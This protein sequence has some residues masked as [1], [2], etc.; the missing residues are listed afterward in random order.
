MTHAVMKQIAA[1]GLL[2]ALAVSPA[3]PAFAADSLGE[4]IASGDA[5]LDLRYRFEYVEQD[6]FSEKANASTL[7]FRLNYKTAAINGW[8]GFLEFDHVTELIVDDFNSGMGTS[9]PDRS[10]YPV[11]ADPDG[12]DLNQLYIQYSPDDSVQMRFGRQRILLD[13]QRFVGGVGWRQNEQTYDAFSLKHTGIER[14]TFFYSFVGNVN[15]IFGSEV[16]A[17]DNEQETH[18]LNVN[19]GLSENWNLTGYAYLIDNEDVAAFSTETY[20]LRANGKLPLGEGSLALLGEFAMQSEGDN[21]SVSYDADYFRVQGTWSL[22]AFS[23]GV[24]F[25]SLGSDNSQGFRTPLAT[26]HA[27]NGWADKFLGT[28]SGGLEDLYVKFGYKLA[29]WNLQLIYH[30]FS[31]ETGST[32]YGTEIDFSAA[33]SLGKRYKLLLKLAE[34]NGTAPGFDDTRKAWLMLTAGF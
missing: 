23:T 7:R 28:P 25:E 9:G 19:V 26:L 17:G 10:Q 20:G 6:P 3:D 29:S 22:D 31:A 34:F 14:T 27:F 1:I 33:R 21:A 32:D 8:S 11:V 16:P 5:N 2:A 13:D 12:S 30:D 18:L 15:R 4:A 24:G